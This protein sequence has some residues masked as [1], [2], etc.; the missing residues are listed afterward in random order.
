MPI[1]TILTEYLADFSSVSAEIHFSS[2]PTINNFLLRNEADALAEANPITDPSN[3]RN[4]GYP[5]TQQICVRVD[6]D[7][8]NACLGLGH[9]V[10]VNVDLVP[11]AIETEDIELCDND[12]DEPNNGIV[13][14][15]DLEAKHLLS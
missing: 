4:I 8:D 6:S 14:T 13:Q 1:T 15:F 7:L 2:L 10:T 11:T 9:H 3:Y 5:I 12:D